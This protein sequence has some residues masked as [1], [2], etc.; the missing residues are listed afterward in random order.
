MWEGEGGEGGAE[1][2]GG[3]SDKWTGAFGPPFQARMVSSAAVPFGFNRRTTRTSTHHG[4]GTFRDRA[5]WP[6]ELAS[7]Y[8][9]PTANS[10]PLLPTTIANYTK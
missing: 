2:G 7:S 5:V 9:L 4:A 8:S 10:Q 3:G 6:I 1:S